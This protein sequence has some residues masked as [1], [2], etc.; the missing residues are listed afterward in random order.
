[1]DT[2]YRGCGLSAFGRAG[3]TGQ[4]FCCRNLCAIGG[5]FLQVSRIR[6]R[7][8]R[9]V[10]LPWQADAKQ[11]RHAPASALAHPWASEEA[12]LLRE[13]CR[14]QGIDTAL[15]RSRSGSGAHVWIFFDQP[16]PARIARRFGA[17]LLAQGMEFVHQKDFNTFDRMMPNQDEMPAG[18]MGNLIALPL[19]GLPRK[20]GN[21]VF[22]DDDWKMLHDQWGYLSSIN[23]LTPEFVEKKIAEWG[24]QEILD[25]AEES[26]E[27]ESGKPWEKKK[28][29]ALEKADVSEP[30]SLTLAD[31]VYIPKGKVKPRTLNRIRKIGN[32]QQSAVLQDAGH[33]LFHQA[34]SSEN[35]VFS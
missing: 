15:E 13:I 18:G 1:M 23:C 34:D 28:S 9:R 14:N 29:P 24:K 4:A 10:K 22:V 16:I 8:P 31:C 33:A 26:S 32:L 11:S 2:L 35:P 20:Q 7:R 21:E 12:T 5:F 19:Q 6:L 25:G 17:A 30:L 27:D 3:R